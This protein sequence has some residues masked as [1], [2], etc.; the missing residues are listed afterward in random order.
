MMPSQKDIND[1]RYLLNKFF[2]RTI[3]RDEAVQFDRLIAEHPSLETHYY[4]F[5]AL[6]MSF[7]EL[8]SIVEAESNETLPHID[9]ML[10]QF[11]QWEN[12]APALKIEPAEDHARL[13]RPEPP[14]HV[15]KVNRFLFAVASASMAAFFFLAAY[16]W[17]NPRVM[18]QQVA[19][20]AD[21][22]DA[23]W[24]VPL[25]SGDRLVD[26]STE[27][28]LQRGIAK[29]AMDNGATVV[30][31][32]PAQFAF[33]RDDKM[34]L[35]SGRLYAQVPRKARGFTVETPTSSIIDLG[36]EFGIKIDNDGASS[37]HLF[38]GK[39]S[40]LPGPKGQTGD[41]EMVVAGQ[42]RQVDIAGRVRDV[43]LAETAFAR[44]IDSRKRLVWRGQNKLDLAN[45]V[46]G[47]NG[48]DPAERNVGI[49][50]LSG[51]PA[52]YRQ[53]DRYANNAYVAVPNNPYIDGVFVPNGAAAQ[54]VTSRGDLFGRCPATS[55]LFYTEIT[56][57]PDA[58]L[59]GWPRDPDAP[60]NSCILLHANIGITFDLDAIRGDFPGQT[61]SRFEAGLRI[62][63]VAPRQPQADV[64]I[65][66]DGTLRYSKINVTQKG[67]IE[68]I[69][70]ELA[71]T[72]RFLT[73]VATEGD[74]MTPL[75]NID[76]DWFVFA[77]PA[78]VLE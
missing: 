52:G 33:S 61:L 10:H 38:R 12:V 11:S 34:T 29:I 15:R 25:R 37:V 49:N 13:D 65:L 6:Q 68:K 2:D 18:S 21:V 4:K 43:Q 48:F 26:R 73:L 70:V 60:V 53:E 75:R 28:S 54:I 69:R 31:E 14:S 44:I 39:A 76:S 30:I 74:D 51:R 50:P 40:L 59:Q 36:T 5:I 63:E 77:D 42:A 8:K 9:E 23:Q 41:S 17:L 57:T 46:A 32:A 62:S 64:W 24:A 72:D 56:N 19:T 35:H 55:G 3:T 67:D 47:G 1:F 27:Y 78:I 22:I 45:I 58:V 66:I 16:A 7:R 71:Q 20:L